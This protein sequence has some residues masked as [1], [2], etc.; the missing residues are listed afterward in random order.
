MNE[1]KY[2]VFI[3]Y[4]QVFYRVF[5]ALLNKCSWGVEISRTDCGSGTSVKSK[6]DFHFAK[7]VHTESEPN[8]LVLKN[9]DYCKMVGVGWYFS[10]YFSRRTFCRVIDLTDYKTP[11]T[12]TS[13][14]AC[15]I[16]LPS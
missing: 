13:T 6:N 3:L 9:K 10:S 11:E 8:C 7:K 12:F 16:A 5:F 4:C 1:C 14:C 15:L 2:N